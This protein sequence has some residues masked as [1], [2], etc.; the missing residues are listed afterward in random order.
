MYS[1]PFD[2][3]IIPSSLLGF[4]ATAIIIDN[5]VI[6]KA[7]LVL[8]INDAYT[9]NSFGLPERLICLAIDSLGANDFISDQFESYAYY[10][11]ELYNTTLNGQSVSQ[12]KF[13]LALH[14]QEVIN[15][16]IAGYRMLSY[17]LDIYT[18]A[19][20]PDVE[21]ENSNFTKLVLRSVPRLN[22]LNEE[23]PVYEKLIGIC[24]YIASLTDGYTVASFKKFQGL[25]T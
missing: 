3:I 16:E 12:Y 14:V 19:I 4:N 13:N 6:N 21:E 22:Y 5:V 15:K 20:L 25:D 17:L 1:T 23:Q 24:S 10:G 2:F 9:S 7:E 11:G 8:T 18:K